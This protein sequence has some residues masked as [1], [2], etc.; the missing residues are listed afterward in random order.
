[1]HDVVIVGAGPVGLLLACELGLAGCSVLVLEREPEPGSPWR[2]EPLGLRGLFATSVEAFHRRGML[3]SLL[4]ASGAQPPPLGAGH[5]AGIM[6]DRAKVAALPFR[7]P[8]PAP[9][10][11]MTSLESVETVLSERASKL[12]VEIRRGVTVSTL[13]QD[14]ETVILGD[15]K[16]EYAARWVVG[17]DGGRSA[18]RKLAGFDF[19]GTEPQFTGY[20][21]LTT[22]ADPEKLNPGMNLTPTGMYL[23]MST[24]GHI[25]MM[26]FDG[27]AFDRSQP[28]TL[29]HL[30]AVL[31]RVSGTDVTLSD[32]HLASSFTDRAKQT[33][34][35]RR[36]RVLLAGDAAHIIS[37]LGGQGLNTGIGDAMNLGWKLAATVRGLAPD[38]L[39]DTYTR[40][41]HPVGVRALEWTRA[42]VAA[43]RPD[44][45]SQAVQ[46]LLR[47]LLGTRDGTTYVVERISGSSI[48]YD[49]GS[50]HPLVGR[51]APDFC[52]Q[53]GTRLS[54][55]M[56][57]GRGV[58]LDFSADRRLHDLVQGWESRMRYA[59]GVAE[60]DLGLGAVLVRPD[61][62]VAWAGERDPDPEAFVLAARRWFGSQ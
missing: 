20:V 28:P 31:R 6:L 34:T 24:P 9:E 42:Q 30:Q 18:V 19:V 57:D 58:V 5:F 44:P 2:T 50:D 48:R 32:V 1:M 36:G 39:L 3:D 53:D 62:I 29:D 51:N 38:G 8:S 17:C 37:P 45:H 40:E 33:T 21:A 46:A 10:V 25:G 60:N 7:L 43:M 52:L 16:H 14:D 27:G 49:L 55:L 26:D 22:I 12:G 47:D 61:G 11:V 35:Y 41:R 56:E 23:Q 15:G 4:T 59:T 54:D 13:A